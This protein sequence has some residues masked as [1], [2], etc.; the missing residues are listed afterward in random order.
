MNF[1][2]LPILLVLI[3]SIIGNNHT[4]S[5]AA[6]V[7]LLI[8]MLGLGDWL[9]A[10]EANGV[11][12]GVTVLTAAVLVPLVSG[13]ID[14]NGVMNVFKTPKGLIA[15]S[16]GL[17]V[18]WIAGQ[19]VPFMKASPETVTALMVGTLLGVCFFRGLAVGPLIAGGMVAL[20]VG[21][22]RV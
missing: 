17:A 7:L 10:I 16:V 22:L 14:A 9:P 8:K 1:D 6:L 13:R 5:I 15:V 20:I 19:G 4:V 3:I 2:N 11:G 12:I 18:A 21:V